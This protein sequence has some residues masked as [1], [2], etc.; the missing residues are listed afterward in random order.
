MRKIEHNEKVETNSH[1]KEL[2][3]QAKGLRD[4]YLCDYPSCFPVI[5]YSIKNDRFGLQFHGD[6]NAL[7]GD[8]TKN[9]S[10]E[11][12]IIYDI[13]KGKPPTIRNLPWV[14]PVDI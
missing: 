11:R 3:S 2:T 5:V 13:Y 14:A 7:S 12:V 1:Y 8:I 9:A 10:G 4:K 6:W